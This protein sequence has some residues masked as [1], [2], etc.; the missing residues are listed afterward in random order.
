[1]AKVVIALTS[2]QVSALLYIGKH[3]KH[4]YGD[5]GAA[6]GLKRRHFVRVLPR[7]AGAS[8]FPERLALTPAGKAAVALIRALGLH[9]PA[10]A[11]ATA[12][13]EFYKKRAAT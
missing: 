10:T 11:P 6:D 7:K 4:E 13:P 8:Y 9:K 12:T 2:A 1:M 3:R 5:Y